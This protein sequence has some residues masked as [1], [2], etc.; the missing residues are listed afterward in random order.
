MNRIIFALSLLICHLTY[1]TFS[2]SP[3]EEFASPGVVYHEIVVNSKGDSYAIWS[4]KTENGYL[5]E[6]SCKP[7]QKEWAPPLLLTD[8]PSKEYSAPRIFVSSLDE[9][10][11]FWE[12]HCENGSNALK[13]ALMTT[14]L[15]SP[16]VIATD[17]G[18]F[19]QIH[20]AC[21]TRGSIFAI[22]TK[23]SSDLSIIQTSE[24]KPEIQWSAPI[25]LTTEGY[26]FQ[27]QVGADDTG[28]V[29]AIWSMRSSES[30]DFSWIQGAERLNHS[31]SPPMDMFFNEGLLWG[32]SNLDASSPCLAVNP[33]GDAVALWRYFVDGLARIYSVSRNSESKW[34]SSELISDNSWRRYDSMHPQLA[35]DRQGNAFATW[36]KDTG[37]EGGE[38]TIQASYNPPSE[39][40]SKPEKL[41][42]AVR[43]FWTEHNFLIFP[44]VAVDNLGN[45]ICVWGMQNKGTSAIQAAFFSKETKCWSSVM[46]ISENNSIEKL[47]PHVFVDPSGNVHISW[48]EGPKNNKL[49]K[50]KTGCF[51]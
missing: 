14:S 33:A 39:G 45:A 42:E 11:A 2:W 15:P 43:H 46:E 32:Y 30:K 18:R 23:R 35:I 9:I 13:T 19:R 49:I 6:S 10:H 17:K 48:E 40:W 5:V 31:W 26:A 1:G 28:N 8:R 51:R 34:S 44:K 27:P 16:A 3:V 4:R 50:S 37:D 47:S 41:S 36:V 29:Y 22:W 38:Y 25:N 20:L 24:K 12:D 7:Y 21:D